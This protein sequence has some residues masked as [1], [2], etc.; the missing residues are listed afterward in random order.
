MANGPKWVC[1]PHRIAKQKQCL[2]YS[3]GSNG[4]AEFEKA[5]KEEIR[6][7]CEIHTF[8]PVDYNRRNGYFKDALQGYSEF[9]HWGFGT[10]EQAK[11]DPNTT[12]TLTQTMEE[13]GHVGRS[14]DIQN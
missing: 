9:H 11:K 14:I 4:K 12:K 6:Q 2:V 1:D 13:L 3:V 5:V 7:H 8:D 10:E